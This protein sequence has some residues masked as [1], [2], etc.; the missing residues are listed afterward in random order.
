MSSFTRTEPPGG[1]SLTFNTGGGGPCHYFLADPQI[2]SLTFWGPKVLSPIF[3]RPAP[4]ST[5]LPF[6]LDLLTLNIDFL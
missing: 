1:Y 5:I 2:L 6:F 4:N 3:W